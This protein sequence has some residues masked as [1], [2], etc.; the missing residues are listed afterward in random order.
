VPDEWRVLNV[1]NYMTIPSPGGPQEISGYSSVTKPVFTSENGTLY[2][3]L[4]ENKT[5]H[6]NHYLWE[7]VPSQ[8]YDN[9][10]D[11]EERLLAISP[12]GKILWNASLGDYYMPFSGV[13]LYINNG[14]IFA[15]N[16]YNVTVLDN[17]G[18]IIY[19]LT[20]ISDPPAVDEWGFVY[21]S[22]YNA[23]NI[24]RFNDYKEPSGAI[25]AYYPNGTLCWTKQV[26]KPISRHL[27]D[28][29]FGQLSGNLPIYQGQ[30][31]YLPLKNGAVAL[32]TNGSTI[33]TLEFDMGYYYPFPLMPID[34]GGNIYLE[35]HLDMNGGMYVRVIDKAGHNLTTFNR[36]NQ[37]QPLCGDP[38]GGRLY[39]DM[40]VYGG[41]PFTLENLT[42]Y[43]IRAHDLINGDNDW[44][45]TI[46][47]GNRSSFIIDND[48]ISVLDEYSHI[49]ESSVGWNIVKADTY[50][51]IIGNITHEVYPYYPL[52]MSIGKD[53]IYVSFFTANYEGPII[54]GK[55]KCV[56]AG[57]IYALG[58]NGT[59]LWY[60]P[61]DAFAS[62]F[63]ANNNTIY[64]ATRDGRIGAGGMDAIAGGITLAAL[65]YVLIRFFFIGAVARAKDRLGK[66]ENRNSVL[67]YIADNP[68]ST[69]REVSRGL[70]MNLGTLRYHMFILGMNHR[71][72][73]YMA[74][75]KHVRYFTN[76][77]TFSKEE[78]LIISLL[79]RD[80][81]R[82]V[83]SLL[84][85]KPGLSNGELSERLCMQDSAVSRYMKELMDHGIVEKSQ[86]QEGKTVFSI[87]DEH[88][89]HIASTAK[90]ITP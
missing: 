63:A 85:E 70:R 58:K 62:S 19:R 87:K 16:S 72:V 5:T 18:S 34:A 59:L 74:D 52:K 10:P 12:D 31:L 9:N 89:G 77:N 83:L 23:T 48:T 54:L 38:Y 41:F 20:G 66:N 71:V 88:R 8:S 37:W 33:W 2:V 15:F 51:F 29:A 68:G 26:D 53:A 22:A 81:V 40:P 60:K 49:S 78:Q 11:I 39:E 25:M 36:I 56:Y 55:S 35:Y 14:T 24:P 86:T 73:S 32:D 65:A 45:F 47:I 44:A 67:K 6:F 90:Q 7:K 17:S 82:R 13:S 57:G 64:Y 69:L 1:Y 80:G 50:K 75:D 27:P 76:S 21:A 30:M 4:R 28:Q 79:R 46:P 43:D 61:T 84:Q 3:Y 42:T